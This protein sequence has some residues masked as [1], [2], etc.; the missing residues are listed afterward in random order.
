MSEKNLEID[1]DLAKSQLIKLAEWE[2]PF[3][4]YAG[5]VLIDLP[6]PYLLWFQQKGWPNG[7]LGQLLQLALEI[8]VAGAE[9]VVQ[10]LKK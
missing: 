4:K 8:R 5:T 10:K 7:E 6:E 9:K 2:M 3:G 1:T